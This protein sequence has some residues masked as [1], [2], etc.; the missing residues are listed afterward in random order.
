MT[1]V[2]LYSTQAFCT[3]HVLLCFCFLPALIGSVFRDQQ[4]PA[5]ANL[6]M[7]QALGFTIAYLYSGHLCVTVKLYI[8]LA[9]VVCSFCLVL[10][11]ETRAR[12]KKHFKYGQM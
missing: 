1:Q 6:R 2:I 8:A 11:V 5:F 9:M 4:E 10:V 12:R 3:T 7:F